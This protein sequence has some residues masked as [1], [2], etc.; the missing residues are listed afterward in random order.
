M[1]TIH[2]SEVLSKMTLK[3]N[4]TGV[5]ALRARITLGTWL[6]RLATRVMGVGFELETR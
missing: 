1:L 5:R 2:A 4:I 3:V 6:I